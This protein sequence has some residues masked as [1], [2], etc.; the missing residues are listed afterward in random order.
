VVF[1]KQGYGIA[2]KSTMPFSKNYYRAP[3][4][5]AVFCYSTASID[6]LASV[7]A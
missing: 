5:Q 6:F 2:D 4:K 7:I 1:I 3:L